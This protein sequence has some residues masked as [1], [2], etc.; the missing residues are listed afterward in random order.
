MPS[1]S[2]DGRRIAFSSFRDVRDGAPGIYVMDA[3]GKNQTKLTN[4][5]YPNQWPTWSP[6]GRRIA[7]SSF[8]GVRWDIFVMDADGK[9]H[10][11][12]HERQLRRLDAG[13]VARGLTHHIRV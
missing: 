6:D 1:W 13:V 11:P 9:K 3:D 12:T 4:D 8:R 10:N 2:P 5:N 7:F